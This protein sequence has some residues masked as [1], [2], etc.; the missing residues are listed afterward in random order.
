MISILLADDFAP[1]RRIIRRLLEEE[2][3][4]TVIGEAANGIDAVKLVAEFKPDVLITDMSMPGLDGIE[5]IR[6]VRKATPQ[7]VIVVLSAEDGEKN[8]VAA[9][10]AGASA[11]LVKGLPVRELVYTVRTA[12][13]SQADR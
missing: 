4:L 2:A 3:D 9:K 8:A 5:V 7:T 12:M 13:D 11:Y 6:Q 10:Q 1:I